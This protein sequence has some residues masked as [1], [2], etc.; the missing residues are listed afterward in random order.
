[1]SRICKYKSKKGNLQFEGCHSRSAKIRRRHIE[2]LKKP[3]IVRTDD[4][5][6]KMEEEI[7][8]EPEDLPVE[9]AL[10]PNEISLHKLLKQMRQMLVFLD[11][12]GFTSIRQKIDDSIKF[13]RDE[14]GIF[15][16]PP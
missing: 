5:D 10:Q 11:S 1:M 15:Y 4:F 12:N 13:S 16:V 7:E 9:V 2:K 3:N 14:V 8:Q 6:V